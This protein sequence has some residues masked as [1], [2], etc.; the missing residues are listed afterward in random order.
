V[1]W[2]HAGFRLYWAWV[3]K[4]R[5]VGGRKRVGKEIRAL[6]FRMVA[7]NPTWGAPRIH[8]E[9][10]KLAEALLEA[11]ADD[12]VTLAALRKAAERSLQLS[13]DDNNVKLAVQH[14]RRRFLESEKRPANWPAPLQTISNY[15]SPPNIRNHFQ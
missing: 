14:Q 1:N 13:A 9:L 7:E 3:S 8:G 15:E 4:V 6:I 11:E 10:L 12:Q 5:K 2:H